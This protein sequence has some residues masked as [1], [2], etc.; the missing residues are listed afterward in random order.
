MSNAKSLQQQQ[1]EGK[2]QSLQRPT[3]TGEGVPVRP[4]NLTREG[5]KFWTT[6]IQ[7]LIDSGVATAQDQQALESMLFW[8]TVFLQ[9]Q[10]AVLEIEDWGT[11][12]SQRTINATSKAYDNYRRLAQQFGLTA[13]SRNAVSPG[14]LDDDLADFMGA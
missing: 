4:K 7:P 1:Y 11:T 9:S 10:K 2:S 14:D 12:E 13:Q 8:W 6:S 3:A 5:G